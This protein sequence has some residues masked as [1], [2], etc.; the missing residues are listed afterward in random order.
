[1][2]ISK[3]THTWRAACVTALSFCCVLSDSSSKGCNWEISSKVLS[4][5]SFVCSLPHWSHRTF[6]TCV[7]KSHTQ[8]Y[9]LIFTY[10]MAWSKLASLAVMTGN[11]FRLQIWQ[12]WFHAVKGTIRQVYHQ[13]FDPSGLTE[14]NPSAT[15][16]YFSVPTLSQQSHFMWLCAEVGEIFLPDLRVYPLIPVKKFTSMRKVLGDLGISQTCSVYLSHFQLG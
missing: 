4:W 16:L 9:T 11:T 7:G 10:Q 8:S 13:T 1:M 15:M 2:A 14:L 6:L 12:R 5:Y 3:E